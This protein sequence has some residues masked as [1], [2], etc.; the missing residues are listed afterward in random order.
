M[1]L[2]EIVNSILAFDETATVQ[3]I[4]A[5][6]D[7]GTEVMVILNDGLIEAMDEVGKRYALGVFFVPEMLMSAQAMK[8][9]LAA[10]RP[11]FGDTSLAPKGSIVIGTV[12]GD[13]HD[14][15]KNL[16]AMMLECAGF[17]VI[18]LGVDVESDKFVEAAQ[19]NDADLVALSALIM[20]TLGSMRTTVA[21]IKTEKNA[22]KIL[23]GGAPVTQD[24]ADSIGADGFSA[25]AIGAV[26]VA[27]RLIAVRQNRKE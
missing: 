6:L 20:T 21:K 2:T 23:V 27:R 8:E 15:G 17:K 14:I 19:Q 16:V 9:G 25:D 4:Q 22:P 5:E 13:Q 3:H 12:K 1:A 26:A 11:H 10:L 7:R 24:F 18:N